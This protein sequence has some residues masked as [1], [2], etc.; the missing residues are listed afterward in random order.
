MR[1]GGRSTLRNPL[2]SV[3]QLYSVDQITKRQKKP[4]TRMAE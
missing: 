2:F 4:K 1:L 3:A